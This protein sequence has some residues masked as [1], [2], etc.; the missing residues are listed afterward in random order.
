MS[1]LQALPPLAGELSRC[2]IHLSRYSA[3][4]VSHL[5]LKNSSKRTSL[6]TPSSSVIAR[7]V[8]AGMFSLRM[9]SVKSASQKLALAWQSCTST[10]LGRS[11]QVSGRKGPP[12]VLPRQKALSSFFLHAVALSGVTPRW[13]KGRR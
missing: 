11:R 13:S 3:Q 6:A 1:R 7:C 8:A 5:Y 9:N 10:A 4:H 12:V 2:M